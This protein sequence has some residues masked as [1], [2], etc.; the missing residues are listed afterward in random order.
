MNIPPVRRWLPLLLAAAGTVTYPGLADAATCSAR[1]S[2]E[3]PAVV[4]LYTSEGCDSCPQADRWLA[5]LVPRDGAPGIIGLAFHVDYWDRL[6][7][8]DRFASPAWT[9]RQ[10][11]AMRA[12]RAGF[13]YTPQVLLQGRDFAAWRGRDAAAAVAGAAGRPARSD[14]SVDVL[15][16]QDVIAVKLDARVA[17]ADR[18]LTVVDVAYVDSG[19]VSDVRS[20]ENAGARLT[21][22][23]V[24]RALGRG[25][26]FDARGES[27]GEV[28]LPL[29]SER[30]SAPRIVALVR[31]TA[32][33]NV[34]QALALPLDV[35]PCK[36]GR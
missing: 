32:T 31:N 5:A 9:E 24:V 13:V 14:L 12:N 23:H 20:G 16:R 11:Q 30:G 10:Y 1:G 29:P 27:K 17:P 33:G 25:P 7:W 34:L 21:H 4:E 28:V 15:A 36:P 19:L 2:P 3:V 6:G 8:K 18:D 22:D 26:A 35:S